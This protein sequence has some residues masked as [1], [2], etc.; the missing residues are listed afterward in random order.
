MIR[1]VMDLAPTLDTVVLVS[2]PGHGGTTLSALSRYGLH[3]AAL[4]WNEFCTTHSLLPK[5]KSNDEPRYGMDHLPQVDFLIFRDRCHRQNDPERFKAIDDDYRHTFD[6]AMSVSPNEEAVLDMLGHRAR[7]ATTTAEILVAVRATQRALFSRGHLM[8][9]HPDRMLGTLTAIQ[10]PRPTEHHWHSLRAYI[11]PE[12][13]AV[14]ALYLLGLPTDT[15]RAVTINDITQV[16]ATG[17]VCGHPIPNLARPYL[18]AQLERRRQESAKPSDLFLDLPGVR[19]HQE[20]LTDARR[21]LG[22][23]IDGKNLSNDHKT[24]YDR[25]LYRLGIQ[26]RDLT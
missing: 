4:P 6:T 22:L 25:A 8:Q 17:Q 15:I 3:V 18:D 23:P 16:L 19:Q 26:I 20:I 9:A 11:R 5:A 7:N 2:E 1:T 14:V 12:R 13:A 10:P 21:D 24:H